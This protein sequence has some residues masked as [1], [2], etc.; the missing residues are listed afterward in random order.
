MKK[1]GFYLALIVALRASAFIDTSLQMQLGNPSN[2]TADTNNHSHYLIQ[3]PIE[4]L[5]YNDSRGQPNWA[6]WDLTSGDTNSAV[7]RQDSYATDSNLPPNF[8]LV[9][10]GEYSGSGF[11]R[12]HL[13]PSADRTDSTNDNNLTFLM[14]NMMPQAPDNNQITWKGFENYCRSL[15][16]A[17]NELL[18]LCGPSGFNS[19]HLSSSTRILIP[20]NTWKIVVIVPLGSG[21]A[22]SRITTSTNRV[23]TIRVP[24]TNGVSA[25]WSNYVTSAHEI[26]L[27]TGFSFFTALPESIATAFRAKIDSVSNPPPGVATLAGWNASSLTDYGPSPLTPTTNAVGLNVTGLTRG[28]GVGTS[29]TAAARAWG[30]TGWTSTSSANAI[31]AGKF[32]TFSVAPQ[33]GYKVTFINISHFD[34]RRSPTGPSFGLVQYNLNSGQCNDIRNISY[35]DS[36]SSGASIAPIDLSGITALQNVGYGTNVTFRIVNYGATDTAGT[37]YIFDVAQCAEPDFAIN[38]VVSV[39]PGVPVL[40]GLAFTNNQ[41]QLTVT[42]VAGYKYAIEA[43]TNLSNWMAI[44]TNS[45]PFAFSDTNSAASLVHFYRARLVP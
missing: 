16:G 44:V 9:G 32:I 2:A 4:A 30:G 27:E 1:T 38:G 29:G 45:S 39:V 3:R 31:D 21:T 11:D 35:P 18:I 34:Y 43:S 28:L 6:S 36:T 14:S 7:V 8:Y 19:N 24:N 17:G 33:A 42:G 37:W 20:S 12:G 25:N 26:E 41:F 5:D 15:A 23:I 40:S 13:C 10:E 22:L